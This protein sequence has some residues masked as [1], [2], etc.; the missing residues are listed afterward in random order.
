VGARLAEERSMFQSSRGKTKNAPRGRTQFLC[1]ARHPRVQLLRGCLQLLQF[2]WPAR[3]LPGLSKAC[4]G[5]QRAR[6]PR[7]LNA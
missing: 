5:I 2:A 1:R 7:H 4:S 6:A 3:V